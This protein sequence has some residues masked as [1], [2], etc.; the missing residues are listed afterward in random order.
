MKPIPWLICALILVTAPLAAAA[1]LHGPRTYA[2]TWIFSGE[3]EGAA[4][5]K[6]ELKTPTTIA[7]YQIAY[8]KSCAKVFAAMADVAAWRPG[9]GGV[10]AFA[11]PLRHTILTF[12]P[13]DGGAFVARD[14]GGPGY[15]LSRATASKPQAKAGGIAGAWALNGLGGKRLCAFALIGAATGTLTRTGPCTPPWSQRAWAAFALKG[16]RL[17]L[18][19]KAGKTVLA[20]KRLDA[21]TFAGETAGGDPIYFLRP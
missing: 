12:N 9:P 16:A 13:A 1:A 5:C 20:F 14:E 19:D 21:T 8:P 15:V 4:A 7:G 2:G 11:D 3:A 10:L 6:L 18:T 17:T